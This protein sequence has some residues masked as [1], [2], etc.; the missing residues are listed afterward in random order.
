M[1]AGV[2]LIDVIVCRCVMVVSCCRCCLSPAFPHSLGVLL[3]RLQLLQLLA[4]FSLA[5]VGGDVLLGLGC[6]LEVFLSLR[7]FGERVLDVSLL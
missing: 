2:L 3:L 6:L 7:L 4:Q 1:E 5:I